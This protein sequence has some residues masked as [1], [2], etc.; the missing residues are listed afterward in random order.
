MKEYFNIEEIKHKI[1][2][3][4]TD[5]SKTMLK[6]GRSLLEMYPRAIQ[7][8][9]FAHALH[10]ISEQIR[11]KYPIVDA[12]V[13]NVKKCFTKCQ[14]NIRIFRR[15]SGAISIPP[16]PVLTRWGTW[17]NAVSYHKENF[18]KMAIVIENLDSSSSSCIKAV[19]ELLTKH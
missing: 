3:I 14:E 15:I 18:N 1:L 10:N 4:V 6:V 9:C 13:A 11:N 12:Y 17:I 16:K 8:T 2:V 5:R 7:H 19:K